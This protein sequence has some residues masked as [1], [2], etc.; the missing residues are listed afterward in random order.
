M[1][2]ILRSDIQ[3]YKKNPGDNTILTAVV[4]AYVHPSFLGI[5]WFRMGRA[6]WLRR[7]NLLFLLLLFFNRLLYPLVRLYSGLELSP[8]AQIG[9][10]LWIGHF[11]PTVIHVNVVAGNNLTILQGVTIGEHKSGV[12]RLGNNVSI[13]SGAKVIGGILVGDNAT[14][15]AGAVVTIDVPSGAV[16]GGIPAK[17]LRN[18]PE[19]LRL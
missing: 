13:G 1:F 16:V 12:P 9:P 3:R 14:I 8:R 11:G 2:D 15:A 4:A 7:R 6:F 19:D 17:E 10:G 5:V 18:N